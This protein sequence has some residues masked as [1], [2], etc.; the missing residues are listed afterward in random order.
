MIMKTYIKIISIILFPIALIIELGIYTYY[1]LKIKWM[2]YKLEI[3]KYNIKE[4]WF[5]IFK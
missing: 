1:E 4:R 3:N 2:T 5:T